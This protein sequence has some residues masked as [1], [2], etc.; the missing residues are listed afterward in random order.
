MFYSQLFYIV[1]FSLIIIINNKRVFPVNVHCMNAIM[2]LSLSGKNE[3]KID[4]E[5]NLWLFY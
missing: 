2:H 3:R 5:K 4:N 1:P